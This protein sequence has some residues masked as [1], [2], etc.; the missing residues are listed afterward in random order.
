MGRG[1]KPLLEGDEG[2]TLIETLITILLSFG[3]FGLAILCAF[4]LFVLID[5]IVYEWRDIKNMRRKSK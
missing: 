2:M 3:I 5:A 1:E 4:G